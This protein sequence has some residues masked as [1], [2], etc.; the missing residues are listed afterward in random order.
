[1]RPLAEAGTI[2]G[3]TRRNLAYVDPHIA[4]P[5]EMDETIK[6]LLADAQTSGGL[7]IGVAEERAE[8]LLKRLADAD[9]VLAAD[10]IGRVTKADPAGTITV[11][12]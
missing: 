6:L 8:G 9:G 1:T 7:L 10:V 5:E 3:G 2:P 12:P 4:W 11:L